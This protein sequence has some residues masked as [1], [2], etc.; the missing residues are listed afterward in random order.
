MASLP[1]ANLGVVD[2]DRL[3]ERVRL[4]FMPYR[5]Y[6]LDAGDAGDAG[7]RAK[8]ARVDVGLRETEFG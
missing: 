8:R 6:L 2:A 3:E 1:F 4:G 5:S 7:D